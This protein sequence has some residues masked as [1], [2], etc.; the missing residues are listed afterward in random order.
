VSIDEYLET[1]LEKS[2]DNSIALTYSDLP[3]DSD[4]IFDQMPYSRRVKELLG[5]SKTKQDD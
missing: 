5:A 3:V 2:Y 4:T 1:E